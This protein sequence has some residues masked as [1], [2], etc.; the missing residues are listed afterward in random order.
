MGATGTCYLAVL[1]FLSL[2]RVVIT[3][4]LI[5]A[6]IQMGACSS[7]AVLTE[8]MVSARHGTGTVA[9]SL[10][11]GPQAER[12]LPSKPFSTPSLIKPGLPN[13]PTDGRGGD[14]GDTASIQIS[15]V[16]Q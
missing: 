13:A 4:Q 12:T 1:S 5:K 9:K 8:N 3:K 7:M 10:K 14:G 11:T 16:S 2:Q 6:R 15:H